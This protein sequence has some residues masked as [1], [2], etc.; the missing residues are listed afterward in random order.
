M[1][2]KEFS[3]ISPVIKSTQ[4][5]KA[6]ETAIRVEVIEQ[7]IGTTEAREER[8]RKLPSQLVVCL[9]IAMSIW[10]LDSMTTVLKNQLS[11]FSQAA[12]SIAN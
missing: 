10:S 11:C 7:T 5:F 4:V 6:I 9:V 1:Q 3:L 8:K 2:L 12:F